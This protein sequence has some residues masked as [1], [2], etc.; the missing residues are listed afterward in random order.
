[1]VERG[2]T[3]KESKEEDIL[4]DVVIIGIGRNLGPFTERIS[5]NIAR[6]IFVWF[7][8]SNYDITY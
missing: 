1:M 8:T 7:M 5:F 2:K 4:I 6:L 3:E